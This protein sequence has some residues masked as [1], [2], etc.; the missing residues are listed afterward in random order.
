PRESGGYARGGALLRE[1]LGVRDPDPESTAK[2]RYSL[3]DLL[4]EEG[5]V[6]EARRLFLETLQQ[7]DVSSKQRLNALM[8]L[9]E[10][11]RQDNDREAGAKKWNEV[12][13]M[14]RSQHDEISEAI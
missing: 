13:E 10:L 14:A 9:A 12:L 7:D 3:A 11:D 4:R 5:R 6:A 2:I 8:G 1:G